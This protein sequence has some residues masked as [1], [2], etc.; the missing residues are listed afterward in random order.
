MHCRAL[1]APRSPRI[2]ERGL[3]AESGARP[4]SGHIS[5]PVG[6]I[7]GSPAGV[8]PLREVRTGGVAALQPRRRRRPM[9]RASDGA[10]LPRVSPARGVRGAIRLL[11]LLRLLL[12]VLDSGA[13]FGKPPSVSVSGSPGFEPSRRP[14]R[15]V[16]RGFAHATSSVHGHRRVLPC[17]AAASPLLRGWRSDQRR[18]CACTPARTKD[19]CVST[20]VCLSSAISATAPAASLSLRPA[21]DGRASPV[22]ASACEDFLYEFKGGSLRSPPAA[23][24]G[25][26]Q[27]AVLAGRAAAGPAAP[28]APRRPA[29]RQRGQLQP[30]RHVAG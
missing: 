20:H 23:G 29:A 3:P 13:S 6:P 12:A 15:P 5:P 7:S 11:V 22:S 1:A 9:S 24:C 30:L 28:G 21:R 17:V 18:T 16:L 27:A 10:P 19:G 2:R 14:R 8:R 4:Q 26:P 25:R